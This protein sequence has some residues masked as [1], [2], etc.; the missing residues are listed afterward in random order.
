MSEKKPLIKTAEMTDEEWS[1]L[2]SLVAEYQE[3]NPDWERTG[4]ETI[5]DMKKLIA[6]ETLTSDREKAEKAFEDADIAN[7]NKRAEEL[8][9][10]AIE[11]QNTLRQVTFAKLMLKNVVEQAKKDNFSKL[12]L[13]SIVYAMNVQERFERLVLEEASKP[14]NPEKPEEKTDNSENPND[15]EPTDSENESVADE[16]VDTCE[17]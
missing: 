6:G 9:K 1:E 10:Y 5:E 3:K 15:E 7:A 11:Y 13:E 12:Q 2:E 8:R 16:G 14:Y 17:E 4:F